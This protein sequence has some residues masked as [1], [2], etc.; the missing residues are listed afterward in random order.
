MSGCK[1]PAEC[2]LDKSLL[3]FI[4]FLAGLVLHTLIYKKKNGREINVAQCKI[5]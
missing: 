4:V 1:V 2:H 5:S 3:V